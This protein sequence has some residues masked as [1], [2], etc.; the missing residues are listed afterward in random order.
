MNSAAMFRPSDLAPA[1]GALFA[2][3]IDAFDPEDVEAIDAL[4][5]RF[6]AHRTGELLDEA[7]EFRPAA[8]AAVRRVIDVLE[9]PGWSRRMRCDGVRKALSIEGF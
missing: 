9:R 1:S 6:C 5:Q 3:L 7:G 2:R 8:A 4:R